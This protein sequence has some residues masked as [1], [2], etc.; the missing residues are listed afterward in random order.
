MKGASGRGYMKF[1][2]RQ[3]SNVKLLAKINVGRAFESKLEVR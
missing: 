2:T 3:L 1:L